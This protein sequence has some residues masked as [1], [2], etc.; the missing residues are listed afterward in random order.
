MRE[1]DYRKR[2]VVLA[3]LSAAAALVLIGRLFSLQVLHGAEY[4]ES[5]EE[6]VTREV[7]I[8][9]K[10]GRILDRDGNVLAE[11]KTSQCVTIVD[12]TGNSREENAR[13]NRIIQDTLEI[14]DENGDGPDLSFD[15]IRS[16]ILSLRRKRTAARRISS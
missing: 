11:T 13:L 5:F 12:T 4:T 15:I 6:S 1:P 8:P 10:R 2:P 16:R 3:L 7:P 14:M 9:A